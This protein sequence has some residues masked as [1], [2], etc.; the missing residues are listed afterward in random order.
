MLL[1]QAQLPQGWTPRKAFEAA[2]INLKR[3]ALGEASAFAQQAC[4][5][6]PSCLEYRAL[7]AWLRVQRGE[8]KSERDSSEVLA[9]LTRA[10]R[11]QRHDLEIRVYRAR[12]LQRLG[13]MEEAIRD[14]SVVASMDPRNLEAVREV[15]LHEARSVRRSSLSGILSRVFVRDQDD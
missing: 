13:R 6:E 12:V 15:R 5:G 7:H 11:E 4:D 9:I 8:I 2:R 14:F 3:G 1:P 10:L